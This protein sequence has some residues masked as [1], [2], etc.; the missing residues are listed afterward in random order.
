MVIFVMIVVVAMVIMVIM[1]VFA[2][3]CERERID[4]GDKVKNCHTLVT[5]GGKQIEQA[6]F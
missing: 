4:V 5:H 1:P 2:M 6:L 3:P